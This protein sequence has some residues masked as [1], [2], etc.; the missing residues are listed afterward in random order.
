MGG[1]ERRQVTMWNKWKK[2]IETKQRKKNNET[3][4]DSYP[5]TGGAI[6]TL[7]LQCPWESPKVNIQIVMINSTLLYSKVPVVAVQNLR[8][9]NS[10]LEDFVSKIL[11]VISAFLQVPLVPRWPQ[12]VGPHG[13]RGLGNQQSIMMAIRLDSEDV[14][15]CHNLEQN[16]LRRPRNYA[17]S[18]SSL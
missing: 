17:V 15:L 8:S 10:D 7:V 9:F 3:P 18:R 6:H 5:F 16:C 1:W 4:C 11:K 14:E 12:N 2:I 13:C